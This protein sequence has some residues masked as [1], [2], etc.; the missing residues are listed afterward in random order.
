MKWSKILSLK[1]QFV[2]IHPSSNIKYL[3][4]KHPIFFH[5]LSNWA[6]SVTL[7]VLGGGGLQM[8]FEL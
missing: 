7:E 5:F 8:F 2:L 4:T 6:I 1:F 3:N